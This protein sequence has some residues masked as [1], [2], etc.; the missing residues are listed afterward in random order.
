MPFRYRLAQPDGVGGRQP[1]SIMPWATLRAPRG[2]NHR[3]PAAAAPGLSH[4]E[5]WAV[6]CGG[7]EG[8]FRL[9]TGVS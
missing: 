4:A 9:S 5:G 8:F 7:A 3:E 6:P 2:G 1:I